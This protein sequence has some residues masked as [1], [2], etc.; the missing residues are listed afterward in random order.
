MQVL[1]L[2]E[3]HNHYPFP[4]KLGNELGYGFD[5]QVFSLDDEQNKVI[6]LSVNFQLQDKNLSQEVQRVF[7]VLDF[8]KQ[9][10]SHSYAR[11]YE[12][13]Q[14]LQAHRLTLQG[15]QEYIAYYYVMD[16][17][18]KIS[19]DERKVFHSILSHEDANIRKNY[20]SDLIKKMLEGMRRG[21]DFDPERVIFFCEE[22]RSVPIFHN[23]L[24]VRNIMKDEMG[25]F[26][27]ID[28]DSCYLEI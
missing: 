4:F 3:Q 11:V 12:Y 23:D 27:L 20:P 22:I 7:A 19:E 17:C 15:N 9:K 16:K 18:F 21:L 2:L 8:L 6:K 10:G 28:F 24:H 5:G 26:K 13:N 1:K 14:I 25:N